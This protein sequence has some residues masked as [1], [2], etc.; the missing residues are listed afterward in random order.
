[1]RLAGPTIRFAQSLL[2]VEYIAG[3][4]R[5]IFSTQMEGRGT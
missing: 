3:E 5:N 4:M 2:Q 1:M